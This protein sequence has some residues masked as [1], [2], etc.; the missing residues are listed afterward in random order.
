M[1]YSNAVVGG[2]YHRCR[3]PGKEEAI[4]L[5]LKLLGAL[6][7][8]MVVVTAGVGIYVSTLDLEQY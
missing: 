2:M 7:A 5:A 3:S 6:V 4:K 8:I 1:R